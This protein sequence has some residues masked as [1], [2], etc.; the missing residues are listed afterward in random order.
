MTVAV[1]NAQSSAT[2]V[3][4]TTTTPPTGTKPP[5]GTT[6]PEGT[7]EGTKPPEGSEPPEGTKPPEGTPP[8]SD[9]VNQEEIKPKQDEAKTDLQKVEGLVVDAGLNVE[10]VVNIVKENGGDLDV[11]TLAKLA[12]K[13]GDSVASL[14]RDKV[15]A[16]Y[17][18]QMA[19]VAKKDQEVYS[20][21]EEAFKG[22]TE[23]SGEETW[24]ELAGWAKEN[25]SNDHRVEINQM[26]AQ[27]G[28][29]AKL[30]VQEMVSAF[31]ESQG[32]QTTQEAE[33]ITGDSVSTEVSG[34][35]DRDTYNR[36]LR[37]LLDSGHNY[38]TS[39]EVKALQNKRLKAVR[40]G[41]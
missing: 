18:S 6:P 21:V 32:T 14:I 24:K 41:R 4:T 3:V 16:E 10:D 29:Q 1:K 13:Y 37:K 34:V 9:D 8:K 27:G 35:I 40:L 17:E 20:Q 12:E 15:K 33:L 23:Q 7:P 2:T 25:V 26:L 11:E 30:A 39:R 28:L 38:E 22:V 31:K 5:E 19:Q 36:E